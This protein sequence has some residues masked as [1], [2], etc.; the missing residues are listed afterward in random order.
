MKITIENIKDFKPYMGISEG[1]DAGYNFILKNADLYGKSEKI[2][3]TIDK[4]LL[5][6]NKI[7][8]ENEPKE[9]KKEAKSEK[10]S[11]K[12]TKKPKSD[13]SGKKEKPKKKVKK[14]TKDKPTKTP[15]TPKAKKEKKETKERVAEAEPWQYTLRRFAAM[16]GKER[17][18]TGIRKFVRE[19]QANFSAKLGKKTPHIDL[20]RQIQ[21]KLLPKANSKEKKIELPQW[22]DLKKQ[23]QQA[24]REKIV[25]RTIAKPEIKSAALS[26]LKKK[27]K[28]SKRR[29]RSCR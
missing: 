19:I 6:I 28:S 18:V 13:D 27:R 1:A 14:D 22:D 3:N 4:S 11:E 25:S 24:A 5:L 12:P 21:E 29:K 2:K 10:P 9:E 15:K 16:C 26:G 8:S 23:C 17:T 7:V 20:I